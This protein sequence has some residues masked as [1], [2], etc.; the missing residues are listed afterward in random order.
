MQTIQNALTKAFD[1]FLRPYELF[2]PIVGLL[3][4]SALTGVVMLLIF[5]RASDQARIAR[6]K[7]R[8]KAHIMEMWI[9]RSDPR[10]MFLAIGGVA[11][12][13]LVY[14]RHSLRPI[15][16]LLVPVLLIMVQLGIRYAHGP[17]PVGATTRVTAYLREGAAP[18]TTPMTLSGPLGVRVLSRPL[19]VDSERRVV[20]NVLAETPGE[21]RLTL[22]TPGGRL[23]R[24][25]AVGPLQRVGKVRA[26][27]ARE[28]TWDAFLYPSA[29]PIPRDS[30]VER[31][32]VEYPP[33]DLRVL[34]LNVH[35]LV[36][37]FAVSVAVGY[38]LKG[39]FGIEV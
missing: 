21:H 17:V 2:P 27:A 18:T 13:N 20:W 28:G 11:R 38:A 26:V 4:V 16:F 37:F 32:V 39:V 23:T 31:I 34:G 9:F 30:V 22:E 19:R 6:A 12:H 36:V 7:D 10:A 1:I 25:L 35:W 14:L 15:V 8:L 5:G 24:S 33:R 3:V 29:T